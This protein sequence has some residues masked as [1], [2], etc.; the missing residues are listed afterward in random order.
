MQAWGW[1]FILDGST[2]GFW[3]LCL[4]LELRP[5]SEHLLLSLLPTHGAAF[6]VFHGE[7]GELEPGLVVIPRSD[8]PALSPA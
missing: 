2:L 7:T 3:S 5:I 1:H 6:C 8:A 4:L